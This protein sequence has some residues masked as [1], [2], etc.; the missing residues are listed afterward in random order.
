MVEIR[1]YNRCLDNDFY[2]QYKKEI[3]EIFLKLCP[4]IEEKVN[5]SVFFVSDE[6][7]KKNCDTKTTVASTS[8]WKNSFSIHI[9]QKPIE[10]I[11]YSNNFL[12]Y[13][14]YHELVHL[15]D[16]YHISNNKHNKVIKHNPFSSRKNYIIHL[17]IDFWNEF[18]AYSHGF[19]HFK[20]V[21]YP[22]FYKMLKSFHNLKNKANSLNG[23]ISFKDDIVPFIKEIDNFLYDSAF[24]LAG[25]IYG[26]EK[27]S[28]LSEENIKKLNAKG[29]DKRYNDLTRYLKKI[30]KHSYG[31][32]MEKNFY[33]LGKVIVKNFYNYFNVFVREK[34]DMLQITFSV[35]NS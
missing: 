8:G 15:Y 34:D 9:C 19:I 2:K 23:E 33:K 3:K 4:E 31:K 22:G 21:Y 26:K 27:I 6:D 13:I 24:Y 1:F 32:N 20:K 28:V 5:L 11:Q 16:I 30:E 18:N 29:L 35:Q 17:G 10:S 7:F 25:N 12:T 14:I